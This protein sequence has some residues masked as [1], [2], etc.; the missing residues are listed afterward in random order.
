V[1]GAWKFTP[2]ARV[3]Y[4]ESKRVKACMLQFLLNSALFNWVRVFGSGEGRGL[5]CPFQP[6]RVD[7]GVWKAWV[8]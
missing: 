6:Y 3:M 2:Q 8:C 1:N 4:M 5:A 7:G